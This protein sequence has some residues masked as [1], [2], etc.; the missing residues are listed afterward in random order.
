MREIKFRCWFPKMGR[1]LDKSDDI[2]DGL[3]N[4]SNGKRVFN[5]DDYLNKE[6]REIDYFSDDGYVLN[7][8]TGLKDKNGVEIYE[9]DVLEAFDIL[10]EREIY[11]VIFI[12][13]AFMGK[14]LDDEEFPYFYLFANKSLSETY[15]VIGNI[16]ENPEL[17]EQ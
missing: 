7:Q 4:L 11:P 15:R 2:L 6:I 13:G 5:I 10:G 16:Y 12:D 9:G 14:R 1:F 17:L 3:I 8:Y